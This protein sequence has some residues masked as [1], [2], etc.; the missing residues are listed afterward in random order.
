MRAGAGRLGRD[1]LLIEDDGHV[2]FPAL[3][4]SGAG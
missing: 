3:S 1:R 4:N 2:R